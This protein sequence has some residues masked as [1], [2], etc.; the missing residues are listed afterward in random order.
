MRPTPLLKG[1]ASGFTTAGTALGLLDTTTGTGM[2]GSYEL[3][4]MQKAQSKIRHSQQDIMKSHGRTTSMQ[5]Y[6]EQDLPASNPVSKNDVTRCY[7]ETASIASHDS[8]Q[9]MIKREWKVTEDDAR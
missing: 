6:S 7:H 2:S 1:F 3:Q 5:S 4:S 8:R 9:I